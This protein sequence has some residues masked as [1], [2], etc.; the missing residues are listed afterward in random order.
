MSQPTTQTHYDYLFKVILIGAE[1]DVKSGLLWAFTGNSDIISDYKQTIGVNFGINSV[2]FDENVVK[3]QIWDVSFAPRVKYLR[4]LY[5]RGASG[6]IMVIKSL[7]EAETI[8][9]EIKTNCSHAIPIFFILI[10]DEPL[11]SQWSEYLTQM[12]I[13]IVPN[14]FTGI[15]WLAETMLSCRRTKDTNFAALYSI[16]TDEIQETLNELHQTQVRSE[17]E[18]LE[19]IRNRRAEQIDLL[20]ETLEIMELPLVGDSVQIF[21]SD[22]FFEINT[23][24]GNVVVSPLKCD[25]CKKSCKKQGRL[26]IIPATDGWS[27]DL[28]R[29]SLLILST[30][31]ALINNQL[32]NHIK[33]QIKNILRCTGYRKASN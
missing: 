31:Y 15:E 19:I 12:D 7:K 23:L 1:E 2:Y 6:C 20:K 18:R 28:D 9:E 27:E 30:I 24:T 26:C 5:F 29:N 22:A 11:N 32:P 8:V 13:E 33:N 21:S 25:Q 10:N 14:G 3:L 17:M 4:P 16:G